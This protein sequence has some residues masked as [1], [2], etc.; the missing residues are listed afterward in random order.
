MGDGLGLYDRRW[1][2]GEVR[3]RRETVFG[4]GQRPAPQVCRVRLRTGFFAP[5]MWCAERTLLAVSVFM[6]GLL[7]E[8][9]EASGVAGHE[10]VHHRL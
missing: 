4:A 3:Q 7:V 6:G 2:Y 1:L 9:V 5:A 10:L 8:T